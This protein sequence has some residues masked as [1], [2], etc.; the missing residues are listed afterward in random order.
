MFFRLFD[1]RPRQVLTIRHW[2]CIKSCA[3]AAL[4]VA[5]TSITPKDIVN[6]C[7]TSSERAI[8]NVDV[9]RQR[10]PHG[11][12]LSHLFVQRGKARRLW[13]VL[14]A[15]LEP[16]QNI[17]FACLSRVKLQAEITQSHLVEAVLY[18]LE[19]GELV[20]HEQHA[21][22]VGECRCNNVRNRL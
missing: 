3:S 21:P 10:G 9:S 7:A 2:H 22:P 19:G 11:S 4:T 5:A 17:L 13:P 20:R 18:H 6:G 16:V 12:K 1:V 14:D 15:L 8:Q